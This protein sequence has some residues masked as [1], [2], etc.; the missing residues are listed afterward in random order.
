M[1][2]FW[3]F[4]LFINRMITTAPFK[5][6]LTKHILKTINT[7]VIFG[8][9]IIHH[10]TTYLHSP[11]AKNPCLLTYLWIISPV[12]KDNG[13]QMRRNISTLPSLYQIHQYLSGS[14]TAI[15]RPIV[16]VI[17]WL[18]FIIL[19]RFAV[20]ASRVCAPRKSRESA[21]AIDWTSG[22]LP[23]KGAGELHSHRAGG[24]KVI[25]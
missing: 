4:I 21:G 6:K 11:P 15:T 3:I 18:F 23:I 9:K 16:V 20:F 14:V 17:V 24:E 1:T 13:S 12:W 8:D 7:K 10:S 19:F 2:Q 5:Y 22:T 25:S